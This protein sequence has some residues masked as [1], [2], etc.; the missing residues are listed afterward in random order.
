MK[1]IALFVALI[2]AVGC[3][4]E[5]AQPTG[6]GAPAGGAYRLPAEPADVHEVIAARE[7]AVD[8]EPIVVVGRIGGS[9]NP[10]VDEAAAF[11]IVDCSLLACSDREGDDCPVPWDYCCESDLPSATLLVQVVDDEG[12]MVPTDARELLAVKEL[13]T[14]VVQGVARRDEANNLTVEATGVFVRP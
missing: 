3:Q 11:S 7:Q 9:A 13:Q 5:P 2:A 12:R 1:R 6:S 4:R 14:V 10:W 8:G